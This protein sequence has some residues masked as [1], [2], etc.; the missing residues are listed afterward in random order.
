MQ[1]LSDILR[2]PVCE[3]ELTIDLDGYTCERCQ[4]VFASREGIID[5]FVSLGESD[6]ID[7][8]NTTWLDPTIVAARNLFYGACARQLDGMRF[9]IREI[10][11]RTFEGCCILEVGMGTG[12]FT[13]WMAEVSDPGTE[14]YAF[15]MSWPILET[16][17][18]NTLGAPRVHLFRANARGRLPFVPNTFDIVLARLAPLG[19]HGVP[20]VRAA[21]DLL[22]P[23]GWYFEA[24]WKSDVFETP[25]TEFAMRHGFGHAEH[26]AWRY[27]LPVPRQAYQAMKL[28]LGRMADLGGEKARRHLALR[29]EEDSADPKD[30][31]T[32]PR[33]TEENLLIA[34]KPE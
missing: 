8:V 4:R 2:C 30:R 13:S 26:H 31:Q 27:Y 17:K 21:F 9:C 7:A 5:F 18:E 24:Q 29:S 32:I 14:I 20:N 28:E 33:L 16:A 11:R 22:K 12:Q 6:A 10:G 34:R 1:T 23:G 25:P 3:T 15:D 19:A